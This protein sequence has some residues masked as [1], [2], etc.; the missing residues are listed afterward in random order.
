MGTGTQQVTSAGDDTT[1]RPGRALAWSVANTAVGRFGTLAIGIVLARLLGP[2]EFGTYAVALVALLAVLSFN[3]LGVSLAIVRWPEDPAEIAPTVTTISVG[4]SLLLTGVA[5]AAAPAFAGAMG[6]PR[7]T[8]VV[9]WLSLCVLLNGVVATPAALLQRLF[10]Q[11]QRM[12]AD[13]VNV[14]V[15][16]LVSVGLALGGMGAM[17]LVVGRLA[18]AGL[19]ALVFLWCSPLPYRFGFDPRFTRRLLGFGLPLAGASVIVFLVGFVDQLIV[20]HLLGP[21]LL[22][23]YV[24]ATNL[25]SWPVSLF[26][27]PLR[28]VAPAMFARLQHDPARLRSD[29][30]RVLRPLACV[31]LPVCVVIAVAA[32]DLVRFVYGDQWLPAAPVFRWLAALA[33]L[34]IFFELAY[35]YLVVLARS[36]AILVIQV[37][38]VLVLVPALW[39][40]VREH[41]IAGAG[42]TLVVVAAL[43]SSPMYAAEFRRVGIS[44]RS[45]VAAVAPAAL[46]SAVA[47]SLAWLV[48]RTGWSP[49]PTLAACGV[50]SALGAA[51]LL[52]AYRADLRVFSRSGS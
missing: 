39:W 14:W 41:G 4:M 34:R 7:A 2:A 8:E 9:R 43:V 30:R 20:G 52:L 12:V 5:A 3:E 21:V 29:F 48:V 23:C 31:T 25:A 24:L 26:S 11:D 1:P 42:A 22:G 37:V 13:Q 36:R 49:F 33:A 50:I 51:L 16:A 18:G 10:R 44:L 46:G 38:W 45:L 32:D 27:Q 19:S 17:S 35:D 40:A 47:G 15:G 28:S 6:D